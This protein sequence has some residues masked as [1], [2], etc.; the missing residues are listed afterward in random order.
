MTPFLAE[1]PDATFRA[2]RELGARLRGGETLLL[3]GPLGAGKTTFTQGL[4][5]G[6][7]LDERTPVRSPSFALVNEYRGGRLPIRHADLYRLDDPGEMADLGLFDETDDTVVIVEWADRLGVPPGGK[8][9]R[10]HIA[11]GEGEGRIITIDEGDA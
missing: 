4:C 6:L 5:R 7:G 8:L 9:I 10:V 11:I 1:S 3:V 2:G